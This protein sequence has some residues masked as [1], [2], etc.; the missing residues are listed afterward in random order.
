MNPLTHPS[1]RSFYLYED[2]AITRAANSTA[3]LHTGLPTTLLYASPDRKAAQRNAMRYSAIRDH[4]I[5]LSIM[6][7]VRGTPD[8]LYRFI[9]HETAH[10]SVTR[11][12]LACQKLCLN[13]TSFMGLQFYVGPVDLRQEATLIVVTNLQFVSYLLFIVVACVT[14]V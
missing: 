9:G 13:C 14:S 1:V 5:V 6:R 4:G 3:L 11:H 7:V 10:R 2:F 12:Y 8:V